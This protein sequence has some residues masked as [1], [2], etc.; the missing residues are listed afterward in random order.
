MKRLC[1]LFCALA[2]CGCTSDGSKHWYDDALG[3]LR[4]DNMQMR[5]NFAAPSGADGRPAPKKALE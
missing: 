4:G 2:F 5:N 1:A 3:D